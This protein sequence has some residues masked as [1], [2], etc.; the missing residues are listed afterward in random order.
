[1]AVDKPDVKHETKLNYWKGNYDGILDG[2][3]DYDW[4][5]E[6]C[7]K[8]VQQNWKFLMQKVMELVKQYV[9]LKKQ[10]IGRKSADWMTKLET[11]KLIKDRNQAWTRYTV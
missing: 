9:P 4:R 8:T 7:D 10:C 2:L 1:M 5:M 11:T 3:R 6:F